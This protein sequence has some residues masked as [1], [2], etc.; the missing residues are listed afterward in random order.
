MKETVSV[1]AIACIGLGCVVD[2]SD[3]DPSHRH[4]ALAEE[5][6]SMGCWDED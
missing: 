1:L 4:A 5:L 6:Q 2:S 3:R